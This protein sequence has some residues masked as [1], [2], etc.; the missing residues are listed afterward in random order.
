MRRLSVP[1]LTHELQRRSFEPQPFIEYLDIDSRQPGPL[2][3]REL[4]ERIASQIEMGEGEPR[5]CAEPSFVLR[6][7]HA[8][9][10]P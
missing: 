10:D 6:D 2:V 7:R 9:V 3:S 1:L 5:R 4:S 8:R